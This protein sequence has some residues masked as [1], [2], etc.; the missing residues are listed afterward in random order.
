MA[1]DSGKGPA[2]RPAK[3]QLLYTIQPASK[4]R[5]AGKRATW[6]LL[7]KNQDGTF[8]RLER[9]EVDAV[10]KAWTA[11]VFDWD[12]CYAMLKAYRGQL[13]AKR[14]AESAKRVFNRDNLGLLDAYWVKEY[15]RRKL[16]D[17]DTMRWDLQRAVESCGHLS[18]LV[19][20]AEELE[21]QLT[22]WFKGK[23][24]NHRR[25]IDRLHSLLIFT[26]RSDVRLQKPREE[27][28]EISFLSPSE[29]AQVVP[30]LEDVPFQVFAGV[31][32]HAGL[33][34]GEILPLRDNHIQGQV[35]QVVAQVDKDGCTRPT[36]NRRRRRAYILPGGEVWLKKW[37]ALPS[38][39][40]DRVRHKISHAEK[41]RA[42][43][44]RA[45]LPED[46]HC[47]FHD[48]R[49]SY[50]VH[51]CQ[52]GASIALVAQCIGDGVGVTEKYYSGFVLQDEGIATLEA[53][54]KKGKKK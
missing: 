53:L 20:S 32:L 13:Y 44:R 41:F 31:A 21:D 45:G 39:E 34:V 37:L 42:A 30:F 51:L 25:A 15:A 52:R 36:K 43:C 17:K 29:F 4:E 14:N 5:G 12:A 24:N 1:K 8:E 28:Q 27:Y 18:L 50:A 47:T 49:H 11:G 33:R 46:K 10:N 2:G 9:S 3:G 19:A 16:V 6:R 26:G 54:F 48:L 35:I 40:R 22:R 23:A 7:Q 38:E